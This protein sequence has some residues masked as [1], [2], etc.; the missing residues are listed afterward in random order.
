MAFVIGVSGQ[1]PLVSSFAFAICACSTLLSD[2]KSLKFNA[3]AYTDGPGPTS[4]MRECRSRRGLSNYRQTMERPLL[5]GYF[6]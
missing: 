5:C 1:E 3:S 6:T 4:N 2:R